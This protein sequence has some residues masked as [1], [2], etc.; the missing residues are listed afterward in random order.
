MRTCLILAVLLF[1]FPANA[2]KLP[3]LRK[4]RTSEDLAKFIYQMTT[5]KVGVQ[6]LLQGLS[7]GG[8]VQPS[9]YK[10]GIPVRE[11]YATIIEERFG[12]KLQG[13][14]EQGKRSPVR[15]ICSFRDSEGLIRRFH[16]GIY[17]EK[18]YQIMRDF[19]AGK[20]PNKPHAANPAM[21]LLLHTGHHWRG[22]A[23][24]GR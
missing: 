19:L 4:A 8:T 3:D 15:E 10:T 12:D 11:I 7:A 13:L 17:E 1:W 16:I 23:D 5:N 21:P 6:N 24:G 18:Q 14:Y 20:T 2:G 9:P 22:V